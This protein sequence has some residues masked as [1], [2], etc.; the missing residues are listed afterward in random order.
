M[1]AKKNVEHTSISIP[2]PSKNRL[3]N[4]IDMSVSFFQRHIFF[5]LSTALLSSFIVF[6]SFSR[7]A[8][9]S[10]LDDLTNGMPERGQLGLGR[11]EI[12]GVTY[13]FEYPFRLAVSTIPSV[14]TPWVCFIVHQLGQWYILFT[15][16]Q[17]KQRGELNWTPE[18]TWNPY[19]QAMLKLNVVMIL[20]HYL[21]TQVFY[22]GLAAS[23]PEISTLFA[24][25]SSILVGFVFEIRRRGL[26]FGWTPATGTDTLF[27]FTKVLK[28]YHGYLAS[29]GIVLTF[30]YHCMESTFAHWTGF[31]HIF[32]LLW[33]S[34]LL[35]QQQH[36]NRYWTL[37]LEMWIL[38][39]GSVVAYY[40]GIL[41][42]A[43]YL[44][45]LTSFTLLFL[46]G[47][48]WG[49][50]FVQ[51]WLANGNKVVRRNALLYGSLGWFAYF[52]ISKFAENNTLKWSFL[53]VA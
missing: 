18:D 36:K 5:V 7:R 28:E 49:I 2:E 50:P 40:Q 12:Y 19:A 3:P 43:L 46:M 31:I 52:S 14:W 53:I 17:A 8:G 22:D 51:E 26:I 4:A 32:L 35:Y 47:P 42:G 37:L 10:F 9:V 25:V 6:T 38:L 30:W 13:P 34:S 11:F 21:Q 23:F 24:G 20:L 48:M 44:M 15:A 33:Q 16:K 41:D 1:D 39:H 27:E 29:F 45:F